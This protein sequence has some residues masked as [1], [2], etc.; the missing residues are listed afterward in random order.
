MLQLCTA[1]GAVP[2]HSE[3]AAIVLLL[4]M[5]V[6]LRVW[7]PPPH[8]T[9]HG[10]HVLFSH[11]YVTGQGS[12]LQACVAFGL[13][14]EHDESGSVRPALER[15]V[16]VRDWLPPPHVTEQGDQLEVL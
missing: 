1:M 12:V 3:L 14:G 4:A 10:F 5:H 13:M 16:T 2:L 8:V 15:H 7:L 9:E 11:A 6:T